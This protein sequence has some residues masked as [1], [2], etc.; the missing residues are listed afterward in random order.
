MATGADEAAEAAEAEEAGDGR[1]ALTC[2]LWHR[3]QLT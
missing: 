2:S 3:D 1:N